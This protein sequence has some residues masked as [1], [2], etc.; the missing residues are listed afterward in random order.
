MRVCPE[1]GCPELTEGGRCERHRLEARRA[2]DARRPSARKRGYDQRWEQTSSDYLAAHR[3]CEDEEGCIEPATEVHHLDGLGP[4]GPDGHDWNNLQ[5]L[6]HRHHSK[7]T[8]RDQPGGWA[9][10][11]RLEP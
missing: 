1:P 6:C 4:L 2:S 3:F 5:A 10:P 8:A 7:R 11:G 9:S